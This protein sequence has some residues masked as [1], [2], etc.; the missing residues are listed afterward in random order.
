MLSTY[1]TLFN[2]RRRRSPFD[3]KCFESHD[4]RPSFGALISSATAHRHPVTH[5]QFDIGDRVAKRTLSG[6]YQNS[7]FIC[8]IWNCFSSKVSMYDEMQCEVIVVDQRVV[9]NTSVCVLIYFKTRFAYPFVCEYAF[10]C[11]LKTRTHICWI[12]ARTCE[13]ALPETERYGD[14]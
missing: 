13:L 6:C 1:Q 5:I 11:Q 10:V 7:T 9:T 3:G 12:M 8:M 2:L 4:E 14:A